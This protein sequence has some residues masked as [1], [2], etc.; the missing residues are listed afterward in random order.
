MPSMGKI[1]LKIGGKKDHT[2][3]HTGG[4]GRYLA[5]WDALIFSSLET[6]G[7][8]TVYQYRRNSK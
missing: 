5:V 3:V 1:G 6:I 7:G 8:Y 4:G 2:S